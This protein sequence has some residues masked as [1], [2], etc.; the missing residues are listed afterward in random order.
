[1]ETVD[2]PKTRPF[3]MEPKHFRI[4]QAT[5]QYPDRTPYQLSKKID[6][7]YRTISKYQEDLFDHGIIKKWRYEADVFAMG[8]QPYFLHVKAAPD[9]VSSIARYQYEDKYSGFLYEGISQLFFWYLPRNQSELD[10]FIST[11]HKKYRIHSVD[12]FQ[13]GESYTVNN[14]PPVLSKYCEERGSA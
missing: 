13:I 6:Y 4:L 14:A 7:D 1:M 2:T 9:D 5:M 10:D 3:D 12:V 11:L 8:F